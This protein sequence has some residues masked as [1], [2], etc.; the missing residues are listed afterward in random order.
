MGLLAQ[1][2]I[3]SVVAVPFVSSAALVRMKSITVDRSPRQPVPLVCKCFHALYYSPI[4][5]QFH[6]DRSFR[7]ERQKRSPRVRLGPTT[8]GSGRWVPR[9]TEACP[10]DGNSAADNVLIEWT[11]MLELVA[12]GTLKRIYPVMLGKQLDASFQE[13]NPLHRELW[14]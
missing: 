10:G 9:R 4:A 6:V 11:M 12:G 2:L 5:N 3:D 14:P 1:A 13:L 8:F 7:R